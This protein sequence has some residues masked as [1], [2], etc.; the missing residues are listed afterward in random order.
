MQ[1]NAAEA[2]KQQ[3]DAAARLFLTDLTIAFV[4]KVLPLQMSLRA[5]ELVE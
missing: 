5:R 1:D 3:S 2:K 4:P